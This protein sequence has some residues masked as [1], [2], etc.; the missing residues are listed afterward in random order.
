MAST[1]FLPPATP[2]SARAGMA[3][4]YTQDEEQALVRVDS[5][6]SDAV[7]WTPGGSGLPPLPAEREAHPRATSLLSNRLSP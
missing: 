6:A 5:P 4:M 7:D 3:T 1:S 2:A